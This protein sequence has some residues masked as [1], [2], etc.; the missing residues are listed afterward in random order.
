MNRGFVEGTP[1]VPVVAAIVRRCAQASAAEAFSYS[2]PNLIGQL[3]MP[4]DV[5]VIAVSHLLHVES[6][7]FA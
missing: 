5:Q 6:L 1:W 4:K 2:V 7:A 3:T